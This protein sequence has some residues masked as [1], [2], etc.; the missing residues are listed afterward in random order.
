[1]LNA[2]I[3]TTT[4]SNRT[5][6]KFWTAQISQLLNSS[7][8]QHSLKKQRYLVNSHKFDK[9]SQSHHHTHSN[10]FASLIN[11]RIRFF[12]LISPARES[13]NASLNWWQHKWKTWA[14]TLPKCFKSR[15]FKNQLLDNKAEHVDKFQ[16]MTISRAHNIQA[17]EL[18]KCEY[19]H[20][21]LHLLISISISLKIHHVSKFRVFHCKPGKCKRQ[22]TLISKISLLFWTFMKAWVK[23]R[24]ALVHFT[25]SCKTNAIF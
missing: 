20:C 18:Q 24:N 16:L 9:F 4:C 22:P 10:L 19:R 15:Q 21:E 17:R 13:E 11:S 3:E 6:N 1:M 5:T 23:R 14:H 25:V 12:T 2:V 8:V 7:L